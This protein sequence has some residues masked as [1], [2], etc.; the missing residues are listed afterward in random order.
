MEQRELWRLARGPAD[1]A[2]RLPSPLSGGEQ[3]RVAIARAWVNRPALILA[4]PTGKLVTKTGNKVLDVLESRHA[5][6]HMIVIV[7]HSEENARQE[8]AGPLRSGTAWRT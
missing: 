5:D 4:E 2:G 8:Q 7:M 3:E 1:K 6:N